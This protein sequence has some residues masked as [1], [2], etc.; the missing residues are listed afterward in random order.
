MAGP[1]KVVIVED[2]ASDVDLCLRELRRSGFTVN[3][4][5][6]DQEASLREALG[7]TDWDVVLSDYTL[8]RFSAMDA[9][10]VVRAHRPEIPFIIVT[11]TIDEESA[12]NCLK[13]GADNY[14]LKS[15]LARLGPA[16]EQ[17]LRM[18]AERRQQR[19]LKAQLREA[20]KMEAVGQ[21]ATGIAHDFNN[22]L[23]AIQGY[24][25]L[26][27]MHA[28]AG[29]PVENA[30]SGI[31]Q[32]CQ[33]GVDLTRSLL[34]FSRR[35]EAMYAPVDVVHLVDESARLFRHILPASIE[36]RANR[37]EGRSLW[38]H[39][40]ATQMQQ[41]LMNLA[42]NARD[43]M[44]GGGTLTFSVAEMSAVTPRPAALRARE[45]ED[46]AILLTVEDTGHGMSEDVRRQVFDPFFTT[47]PRGQGTGLGLPM[48]QGVILDHG[49][50]IDVESE[51]GRGTR[52]LILLPAWKPVAEPA[53][54][55][56]GARATES[57][58]ASVLL[59]CPDRQH[60]AVMAE[61][62]VS[63]GCRVTQ[64][65]GMQEA[66]A[67][68]G[69]AGRSYD[70]IVIDPGHGSASRPS[71]E[72]LRRIGGPCPVILLR[73]PGTEGV[74]PPQPNEYP[75]DRPFTMGEFVGAVRRAIRAGNQGDR[76][77]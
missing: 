6:V 66:A 2:N 56:N 25:Q 27:R 51:P 28:P 30:L 37:P 31:A 61:T 13:R 69:G 29:S 55:I 50:W 47:K 77:R 10:K 76:P 32:A 45:V 8:P 15:N 3:H 34:R 48:A 33:N 11:G 39:G 74:R 1:V 35:G 49:G 65:D 19:L 70:L 18:R 14:V 44:P 57:L 60:R 12:V 7:G 40:D 73:D 59:L 67:V 72:E 62:L 17:S 54:E 5:V 58:R 24:L 26:A 16:V 20:Q 75:L 53:N 46:D 38:V 36:I 23:T 68:C 21:L 63:A 42:V 64:V 41:V 9:L 43:A 22:L 4:R 71:H 52:F